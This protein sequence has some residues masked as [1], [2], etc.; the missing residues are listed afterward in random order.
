[1]R[2][3]TE[4]VLQHGLLV[5]LELQEV[6]CRL[7]SEGMRL[8]AILAG[9]AKLANELI[10]REYGPATA[11]TWFRAMADNALQSGA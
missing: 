9:I 4:E 8:D 6:T 7:Q 2:P 3:I 11:A 10:R 5:A 1:M